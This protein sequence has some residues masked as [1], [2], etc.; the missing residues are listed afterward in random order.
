MQSHKYRIKYESVPSV[1]LTQ[2]RI[3]M[4]K[5]LMRI[6]SFFWAIIL[7][8][9][10]ILCVNLVMDLGHSENMNITSGILVVIAFFTALV[11]KRFRSEFNM[12]KHLEERSKMLI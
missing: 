10:A 4:Q 12:I 2:L 8:A 6:D 11:L 3:S 5:K 7:I 1:Y 9:I